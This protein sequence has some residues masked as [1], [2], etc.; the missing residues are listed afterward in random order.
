M[1]PPQRR[2]GR[3][4]LL[5]RQEASW[6]PQ[7]A[8]HGVAGDLDGDLLPIINRLH[9]LIPCIPR[10]L[11]V[12]LGLLLEGGELIQDQGEDPPIV[13]L[14][15]RD[16]IRIHILDAREVLVPLLQH[17]GTYAQVV[18]PD[19]RGVQLS[20]IQETDAR[21]LEVGPG[22][23]VQ[24]KGALVAARGLVSIT[25]I[26][27]D[28]IQLLR[29]LQDLG[30]APDLLPSKTHPGD[31]AAS[32][33]CHLEEEGEDLQLADQ[34]EGKDGVLRKI[35]VKSYYFESRIGRI[36]CTAKHTMY[37]KDTQAFVD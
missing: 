30:E 34:A 18:G 12:E 20:K 36:S 25:P 6:L 31:V 1:L 2:D 9:L 19:Q 37:T 21:R 5:A 16:P 14:D 4:N 22:H 10:P 24:D 17:Y 29:L 15:K 7:K 33:I 27:Y 23:G 32:S 28:V 3:G 8:V 13:L 11:H 35:T 26:R